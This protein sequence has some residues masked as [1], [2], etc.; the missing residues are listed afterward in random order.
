[1]RPAL[2]RNIMGDEIQ[3]SLSSD[4]LGNPLDG[5]RTYKFHLPPGIPACNFWS[6]IVYDDQTRMI[7]RS[8]QVWPSVHSNSME[9]IVNRDGSVDIWFGPEAP[10]GRENNWIQTNP[11]K[12]WYMMFRLYLLPESRHET[13][14]NPENIEE[15]KN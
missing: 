6:V 4:A 2:G 14:W 9:L 11:G 12:E 7:I 5:G 3:Y 10:A 15:V 1:V 13:S 8:N